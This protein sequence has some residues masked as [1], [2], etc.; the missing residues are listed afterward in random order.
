M[1]YRQWSIHMTS[2]QLR[3]WFIS[4]F[5]FRWYIVHIPFIRR[6]FA[7]MHPETAIWQKSRRTLHRVKWPFF[8]SFLFILPNLPPSS[9][10]Y[11]GIFSWPFIT[12]KMPQ[13]PWPPP[14]CSRSRQLHFLT[15]IATNRR[16]TRWEFLLEVVVWIMA[17]DCVS[18]SFSTVKTSTTIIL[19]PQWIDCHWSLL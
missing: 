8:P 4:S 11:K 17:I 16:P 3:L 12:G 5:Q 7:D 10:G 6:L 2:L 1:I 15:N 19:V 14:I 18:L 13:C 9:I